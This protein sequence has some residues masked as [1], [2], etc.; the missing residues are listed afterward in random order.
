MSSKNHN[1]A[2]EL[3]GVAQKPESGS[4]RSRLGGAEA[5]VII[6]AIVVTAFLVVMVGLALSAVLKLILGAGL[7]AAAVVAAVTTGSSSR[8]RA[9]LRALFDPSD[10]SD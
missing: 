10:P 1:H 2:P 7:A 4:G 5:A 8:L 9:A 6:V 3:H